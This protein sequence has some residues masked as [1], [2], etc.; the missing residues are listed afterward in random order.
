MN[1]L[2]NNVKEKTSQHRGEGLTLENR[3]NI[4]WGQFFN[5]IIFL[6]RIENSKPFLKKIINVGIKFRKVKKV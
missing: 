6:C 1:F 4:R 2:K 3:Q 5:D